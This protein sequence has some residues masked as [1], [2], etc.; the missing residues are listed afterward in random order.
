MTYPQDPHMYFRFA[1]TQISVLDFV[2]KNQSQQRSRHAPLSASSQ[3]RVMTWANSTRAE[4]SGL[5]SAPLLTSNDSGG[6]KTLFVATQTRHT[7]NTARNPRWPFGPMHKLNLAKGPS[8][9][10]WP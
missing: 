9:I 10:F 2:H 5:L 6:I 3:P 1:T 7:T 4:G 8:C